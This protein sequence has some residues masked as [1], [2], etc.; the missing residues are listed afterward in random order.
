[1][2][3]AILSEN[4]I[5]SCEINSVVNPNSSHI[6]NV[7]LSGNGNYLIVATN[8]NVQACAKSDSDSTK[9]VACG[10]QIKI[11]A[12]SIAS[13]PLSTTCNGEMFAMPMPNASVIMYYY[14]IN[15]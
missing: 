11:E 13:T 3:D 10:Q 15:E 4:T 7:I 2:R 9:W 5:T 8:E 14:I 12:Q 1:M 6:S